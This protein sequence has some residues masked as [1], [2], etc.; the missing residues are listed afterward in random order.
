MVITA[1]TKRFDAPK[2]ETVAY[3]HTEDSK[4]LIDT[5]ADVERKTNDE[6]DLTD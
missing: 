5:I 6:R 4:Q 2:Q 1:K 3:Y